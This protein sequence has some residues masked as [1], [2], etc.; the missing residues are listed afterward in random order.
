MQIVYYYIEELN[1]IKQQNVNFGDKYIFKYDPITKELTVEENELYIDNFY[2]EN[3]NI[4]AIIG[5]NGSGKTSL[6]KNLINLNDLLITEQRFILIMKDRENYI[7]HFSNLV[8]KNQTGLKIDENNI[9]IK[10]SFDNAIKN[11]NAHIPIYN[12]CDVIFYSNVF[13]NF[14]NTSLSSE[15]H[16]ISTEEILSNFTYIK[17]SDLDYNLHFNYLIKEYLNIIKFFN[18]TT[19]LDN[20]INKP[21]YIYFSFDILNFIYNKS[22]YTINVERYVKLINSIAINNESKQKINLLVYLL[23]YFT[24]YKIVNFK[25]NVAGRTIESDDRFEIKTNN[26]RDKILG[27][28]NEVLTNFELEHN[29]LNEIETIVIDDIKSTINNLIYK[30]LI[31][32]NEIESFISNIFN[33]KSMP[34]DN[35][36]TFV[37]DISDKGLESFINSITKITRIRPISIPVFKNF[38]SGEYSLILLFSRLYSL[39]KTDQGLEKNLF[40]FIDEIDLYFHPDWQKQLISK[41]LDFFKTQFEDK[42]VHLIFT[43]NNPLMIS[44]ILSYN[45]IFLQKIDNNTTIINNSLTDH[46]NTF[47]ANIHTL[48]SDSFFMKNGAMGDFAKNK[49]ND[50]IEKLN[51]KKG[52]I[53]D[54]ERENIKKTIKLIGESIIRKKLMSMYNECFYDDVISRIDR[55]EELMKKF[56]DDKN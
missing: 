33:I 28:I 8:V 32:M 48:L 9:E 55:L 13:N 6:I 23:F 44:D 3:I 27:N 45:T 14:Q 5:E 22:P 36:K 50:I 38:S 2:G 53:S 26:N 34:S 15:I 49:L 18:G 35:Y 1:D 39:I 41:L 43:A 7:L 21:D 51:H 56:E 4:T 12:K 25:E 37:I 52:V 46:K 31:L 40:L 42:K 11:T 20:L 16:N 10:F 24:E 17:N 29:L 19:N 30:D 47:A 54:T